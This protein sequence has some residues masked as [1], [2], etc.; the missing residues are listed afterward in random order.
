MKTLCAAMLAGALLASGCGYHIAGN[1]DAIPKNIK[2]IAVPAFNNITTRYQLARLLPE[3][4][5]KEFLSRTHYRVVSDPARADAVLSGAV[6]NFVAIPT[7]FDPTTGR[8]TG[9]EAIVTLQLRLT[10]RATGAVLLNRPGAE[11]RERYEISI[12]PTKYFDESST[13]M[14]RLSRDVAESVVSEV[15]EKF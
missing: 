4:I 5:T 15:L 11:F 10:D 2:T 3:D 9:V 7:I 13:A 8:G 12:D 14:M 6:T 1:G